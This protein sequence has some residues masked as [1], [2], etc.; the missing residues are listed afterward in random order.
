VSHCHPSGRPC[1][2]RDAHQK[3]PRTQLE[4]SPQSSC[5]RWHQGVS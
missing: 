4:P 2:Y 5:Q 3:Y 1:G